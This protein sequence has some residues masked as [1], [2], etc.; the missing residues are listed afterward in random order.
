MEENLLYRDLARYYD[1][2]YHYKDYQ[3]ETLI[4]LDLIH[5]HDI[6]Q[7]ADLL[8]VCCG[9]GSHVEHLRYHFK[10]TG[11]DLNEGILDI[12]RTKLPDV[13]FIQGDMMSFD[14]NR[15][16][17]VIL[18]M[19]G[20]IGYSKTLDGLR[21]TLERFHHHLKKGGILFFEP[22]LSPENFMAGMPFMSTYDDA[23]IK[24]ARLTMSERI[25]SMSKI[26]MQYLISE[27]EKRMTH[28]TEVHEMGL[29]HNEDTM[30]I[31][32]EI[33]FD[34]EFLKDGIGGHNGLFVAVK[35]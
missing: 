3:K 22:W 6:P 19:F 33:G 13:D 24:I 15:E 31:L 5:R 27:K 8:D 10:C 23:E 29:F 16:F 28:F 9:T 4:L 34:A 30:R 14:L 35:R 1:L 20:S 11:L 26:E 17:D 21:T 7:E 2:I 18:C 25:G 12:A 32:D